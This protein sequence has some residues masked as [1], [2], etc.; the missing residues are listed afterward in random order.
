[1]DFSRD[2][3]ALCRGVCAGA[4]RGGRRTA[5]CIG[6]SGCWWLWLIFTGINVCW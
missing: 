1:M 3:P 6:N 2:V 5:D 4:A